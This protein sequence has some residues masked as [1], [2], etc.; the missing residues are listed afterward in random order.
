TF[1]RAA[2]LV[3]ARVPDCAFVIVGGETIQPGFKAT[4]GRMADE[5]GIA[6]RIHFVGWQNDVA[7]ILRATDV[8]A[9]PSLDEGLPLA[10][11]EAMSTG[12]PVVAT[13]VGGVAEA[14][15]DDETG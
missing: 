6:G 9:L 11:L 2:A 10:I 15:V 14:V 12:V 4:L 5:L 3:N 1:F 13:P 7:P 8:L